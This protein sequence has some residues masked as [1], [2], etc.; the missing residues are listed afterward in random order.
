MVSSFPHCVPSSR[1]I[2][3][4]VASPR[5]ISGPISVLASFGT[6]S[7]SNGTMRSEVSRGLAT[8]VSGP[9][10]TT[11]WVHTRNTS[12]RI[13]TST[14]VGWINS[15][16]FDLPSTALGGCVVQGN[17]SFFLWYLLFG[18]LCLLSL[19][20]FSH[21]YQLTSRLLLFFLC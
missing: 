1:M 12:L 8:D 15:L 5:L 4:D 18:C 20:F 6:R 2:A 19:A 11:L 3:T 9:P 13:F 16:Y 21:S 14:S 10:K 17:S 7:L